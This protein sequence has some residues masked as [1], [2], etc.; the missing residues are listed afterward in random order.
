MEC[1]FKTNRPWYYKRVIGSLLKCIVILA[2]M[3]LP[4]PA[5]AET[6]REIRQIDL[7]AAGI[8]M[9]VVGC[10]AGA[11]DLNGV[12]GLDKIR[13][14]AEIEVENIMAEELNNFIENKIRLSLEQQKNRAL[15][16]SEISKS[17]L[18]DAMA[19]INLMIA[20]PEKLNV[21]ITD[22]SGP[23]RIRNLIGDVRVDDDSGKIQVENIIGNLTVN[24]GSG[25]IEIEGISGNVMVRDGSG[26]IEIDHVTGDVYVTDGSGD[27]TILHIDGN[28]TVSDDSG[29]IDISDVSRN[30]LISET[31]SGEVSIERIKGKVS[32]RK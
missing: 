2:L 31:V 1:F 25:A 11:L 17:S 21:R 9:L 24:D 22:G 12:E 29:D 10:G 27:M 15:L 14:I 16:I 8:D 4:L 5:L 32:I 19:R 28:V 30:V 7:S 6:A 26:P 23:I 20:V 18:N 13:V 3:L